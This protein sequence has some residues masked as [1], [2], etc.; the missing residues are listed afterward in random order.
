MLTEPLPQVC[1]GHMV[2]R[3]PSEMAKSFKVCGVVPGVDGQGGEGTEPDP[4]GAL[5]LHQESGRRGHREVPARP[6][7]QPALKGPYRK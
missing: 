7:L 4:D 1:N 6:L 5:S 3:V 2:R